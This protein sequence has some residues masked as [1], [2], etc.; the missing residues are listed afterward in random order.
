MPNLKRVSFQ[1]F[2]ISFKWR[3]NASLCNSKIS[4]DIAPS[5]V[6]N[7]VR[8]YKRQNLQSIVHVFKLLSID[9]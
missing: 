3:K 1:N 9:M 7:S 4:L 5:I 2:L 6:S 8:I